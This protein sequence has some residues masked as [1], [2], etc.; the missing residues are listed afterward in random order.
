M[1]TE[2]RQN[3]LPDEPSCGRC[4][5]LSILALVCVS[6]ASVVECQAQDHDVP[7]K[8]TPP[9]EELLRRLEH[10]EAKIRKLEAQSKPS[11]ELIPTLLPA[12]NETVAE[13]TARRVDFGQPSANAL[14]AD[15]AAAFAISHPD[16]PQAHAEPHTNPF[17]KVGGLIHIDSTLFPTSSGGIGF[18]ENPSTGEGPENRLEFRRLRLQLTGDVLDDMFYKLDFEFSDPNE[19]QLLDAYLGFR[20]VPLLQ[21]VLIGN[22]VRPL[23]FAVYGS[24]NTLV[25]MEPA[26]VFGESNVDSRRIGVLSRGTTEDESVNWQFGVFEH[27]NLQSSG[28]YLSDSF[29]GSINARVAATPWYD[30]FSGGQ[31]YVLVGI[32]STVANPNGDAQLQGPPELRTQSRWIN[33]GAIAGSNWLNAT[34]L[35][36]ILN[37]GPLSIGAEWVGTIVGRTGDSPDVFFHGGYLYAAYFLTRDHQP[38]NRKLGV[39]DN[40]QPLRNFTPATARCGGLGA[41]QVAARISYFDL[42]DDDILGGNET[43]FTLGLN[44]WFNPS[45]RLMFNYVVGSIDDHAPVGGYTS[46]H[47]SGLAMRLQI[48]F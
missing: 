38:I 35:E 1:A 48:D 27:P 43:N 16:C 34:G 6:L 15:K 8:P 21:T 31:N 33:T 46:G 36:A 19:P 39:L 12:T 2:R 11:V 3:R 18:F 5:L 25:L 41:W 42:T 23:G 45:S 4:P 28:E 26:M 37:L 13:S 17:V 22:Q 7:T 24:A 44:W 14:T 9:V 32:N 30:D 20:D 10:A 40:V 47:F 29:E